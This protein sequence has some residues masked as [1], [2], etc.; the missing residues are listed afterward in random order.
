MTTASGPAMPAQ[1]EGAGSKLA[2]TVWSPVMLTVQPSEPLQAPPH[3]VN[4]EPASA[5]AVS[6]TLVPKA[7][8]KLQETRQS[9][10]TELEVTWPVPVPI[11][12]TVSCAVPGGGGGGLPLPEPWLEEPDPQPS[13][14]KAPQHAHLAKRIP[15]P[16]PFDPKVVVPCP[17]GLPARPRGSAGLRR[18]ESRIA[19]RIGSLDGR[20]PLQPAHVGA[21]RF[22]QDDAAIGLLP[23]LQD[24]DHRPAHGEAAAVERRRKPWL[25]SLRSEERRVGKGGRSGWAPLQ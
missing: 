13:R 16:Q 2:D 17:R 7:T 9:R 12:W 5:V 6:E 20:E 11:T 18:L 24:R 23:V 8:L 25:L 15:P 14:T 3:P 10:P 22:R 4:F 19:Y 21:D 1:P